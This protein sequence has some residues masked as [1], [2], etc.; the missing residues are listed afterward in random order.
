M[1]D[2]SSLELARLQAENA[3]LRQEVERDADCGEIVGKSDAIRQVLDQVDQVAATDATVLIHGETGTGKELIALAVHQRSRR[4][5]KAMVRVNCG[6]ISAGLVESELFGHEKGAFTGAIER[7]IGRFEL[8]DG[9]TLF[10]DEVAEL[11]PEMQVKLLRVLQEKEFERVGSSRPMRVDVRLIA[12]GNRDLAE[13]VA[14]GRIPADHYY[15]LNVFPLNLPP[16]R[17]RREDIPL[18]AACM[19]PRIAEQ[20]GKHLTGITDASMAMLESYHWPGNVREL[21]N[22]LERAAILSSGSMLEIRPGLLPSTL[23]DAPA[24]VTPSDGALRTLAEVERDHIETVLKARDWV[25]DGPRGAAKILGLHPSTLRSR[26]RKLG[27][28]RP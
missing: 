14:A 2:A 5:R 15:R 23:A 20:A 8:A 7:R 17:E 16:L 22:V 24:S 9:G 28:K 26:M 21:L 25:I 3:Y 1:R 11:P 10:L 12:A 6:A 18:I 27:L 4:R 13:E 19:L